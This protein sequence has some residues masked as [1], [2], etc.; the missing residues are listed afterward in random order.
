VIGKI[1][2]YDY[3]YNNMKA[4][5]KKKAIEETNFK[6]EV[7]KIATAIF[8]IIN[9]REKTLETISK[10]ERTNFIINYNRM[11]DDIIEMLVLIKLPQENQPFYV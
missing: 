11:I 3:N 8:N 9:L 10:K 2:K 7:E 4:K 6:T 5:N 1:Y